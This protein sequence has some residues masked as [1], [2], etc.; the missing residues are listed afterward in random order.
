MARFGGGVEFYLTD[1]LYL[2][3]DTS[4][5]LGTGDVSDLDYISVGWGLGCRF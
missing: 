5:V 1:Y 2:H 4:Y 3:A